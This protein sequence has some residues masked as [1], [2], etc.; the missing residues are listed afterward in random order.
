MLELPLSAAQERFWFLDRFDPGQPN[1]VT[2]TRRLEGP[3]D[4]GLF[5]DALTAV[6]ARHEAL[7]ATFA[8]RDGRPVQTICEPYPF[9][10]TR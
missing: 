5:G 4:A 9:P 1:N 7:R 2:I 6:V 8:E 10:L 3:V